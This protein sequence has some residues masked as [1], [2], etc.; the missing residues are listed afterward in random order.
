MEECK[1]NQ[2]RLDTEEFLKVCLDRLIRL[3]NTSVPLSL[4]IQ[5]LTKWAET[6]ALSEIEAIFKYIKVRKEDYVSQE[7]FARQKLFLDPRKRGKWLERVFGSSTPTCPNFAVDSSTGLSTSKPEEVKRIYLQEG[8]NFLKAGICCPPP[9]NPDQQHPQE[10]PPDL[11]Q[12]RHT[13]TR[14]PP[15]CLPRWWSDMYSRNAKNISDQVW[16]NLMKPASWSEVLDTIRQTD[17]DKAAGYDGVS[18]GLLRMLTGNVTLQ[19]SCL[20]SILTDLINIAYTSGQ[21]L[22]SWRKAIISMIPKKDENG[23]F[24]KL[25]SEMRPISVLQEFGKISSK[26]L[27]NRLGNILL[28]YPQIM[29]PSQRAFL[30]DGSTSQCLHTARRLQG[31]PARP[32]CTTLHAGL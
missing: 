28:E 24:T 11:K 29:T 26:I 5:S 2:D 9:F 8:S 3:G 10:S 25:V 1:S 14:T 6:T 19:P 27:A 22:L 30:K 7:K 32:Q 12:P 15:K 17:T 23:S 31:E 20:L 4:D 18:S 16:E 13:Q 21:S